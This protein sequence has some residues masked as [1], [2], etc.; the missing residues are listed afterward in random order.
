M[1]RKGEESFSVYGKYKSENLIKHWFVILDSKVKRSMQLLG[2]AMVP[3]YDISSKTPPRNSFYCHRKEPALLRETFARFDLSDILS[4]DRFMLGT[5]ACNDEFFKDL[6]SAAMLAV[7]DVNSVI[8]SPLHSVDEEL[9][10][11]CQK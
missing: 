8:F 9:L 1:I 4:D 2:L 11:P 5:G 7:T 3:I 10:R 6:Q